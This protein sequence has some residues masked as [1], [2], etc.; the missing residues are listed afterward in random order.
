MHCLE[1][2]FTDRKIS[3]WGGIKNL[4]QLLASSGIREFIE[5]MDCLPQPGSNRGYKSIDLIEGFITSVVLGARRLEHCGMLRTDQVIREIF[6]WQKGMASASTFQRFLHK[7]DKELNSK[8]FWPVMQFALSRVAV[9]YVT[10]DLDSSVVTRYG[11]QQGA[12]V[13][14]NPKK[15]RWRFS[16]SFNGIL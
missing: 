7:F 11:R 10:I 6:G 14:Y 9:R 13:G 2:Q 1:H 5:S 8:F 12:E 3:P 16:S 4:Q 15:K